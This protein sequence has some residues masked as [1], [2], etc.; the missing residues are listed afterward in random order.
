MR[1]LIAYDG[2][3]CADNAIEDLPRAG[4]PAEVEAMIASVEEEWLK[5]P[6]LSSYEVVEEMTAKETVVSTE[7]GYHREEE[8]F[9]AEALAQGARA[10]LQKLFPAWKVTETAIIGSP[11]GEILRLAEEWQADLIVVGS[12]GRSTVGRFFFGSVSSKIVTQAHCTVRVARCGTEG[13][14][15][16]ERIL[17][18]VDGSL[19]AES[20]V[21]EAASRVFP[22]E[23]EVRL[24]MVSDPL[25]PSLVGRFIPK[26][27]EW[28]EESNAEERDWSR[29]VLDQQAEKLKKVGLQVSRV[30]REGD[31]RRVLVDEAEDWNATTIFIGARGLTG[32]DR[33]LLGS[34]SAAVAQRAEC[35]VEIVRRPAVATD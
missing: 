2:S 24:V 20:A 35:S 27:A 25:K 17:I 23:T 21:D 12:H 11:A 22:A 32:I 34:V 28:V 13:K 3:E 30:I 1:V 33:F 10:K 6:P 16:K 29:D 8:P 15:D 14:Y 7:K 31:P 26:V 4:L 19:G 9:S 5:A 18:A